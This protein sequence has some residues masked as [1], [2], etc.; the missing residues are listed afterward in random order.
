M[1][2]EPPPTI[3][4]VRKHLSQIIK[5]LNQP[6]KIANTIRIAIGKSALRNS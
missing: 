2:S 6:A 4:E 1:Q 3:A 5:F